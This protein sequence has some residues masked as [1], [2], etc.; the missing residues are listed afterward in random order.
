MR[1]IALKLSTLASL[2]AAY[3]IA[4]AGEPIPGVVSEPGVLELAGI[5]AAV[6]IAIALKKR[7]K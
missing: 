2:L 5:G 7:R 6:A 1:N 3:G 4:F